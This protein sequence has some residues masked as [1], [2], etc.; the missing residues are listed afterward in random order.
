V[1]C[2][3]PLRASFFG[4]GT[5]SPEYVAAYGPGLVLGTAI[6]MYVE[7][8]GNDFTSA[9]P[10]RS[11]LGQSSAMHV[12][13]LGFARDVPPAML[14]QLAFEAER[15]SGQVPGWQDAIFA[16]HGGM[17]LVE[18]RSDGHVL[19]PV[20][21]RLDELQA[22][23]LLV[24]TEVQRTGDPLRKQQNNLQQ[25]R[26]VLHLMRRAADEGYRT[27]TGTVSM[28]SF[29]ASV[30]FSWL[31][32][33]SMGISDPRIDAMYEAG[34]DAGAFGGKLLG[35]G[36]GGY[37]LFVVPPEKRAAV[38]AALHV[39]EVPFHINAGGFHRG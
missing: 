25:N 10:M 1:I 24:Y 37:L 30:H 19:T 17:H 16:A 8:D 36:G 22:H 11:G 15:K 14:A 18:F 4:G 27:L 7:Y 33:R 20:T 29:G 26:E 2:R 12:C 38:L 5:D 13:K 34:I 6:D 23:L 3:A 9:C 32:K 39:D 28:R 21:S 31:L 35:A